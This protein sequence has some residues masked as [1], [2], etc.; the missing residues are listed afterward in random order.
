MHPVSPKRLLAAI[1]LA[2]LTACSGAAGSPTLPSGASPV[3]NTP[4]HNKPKAKT[5]F[6]IF[7]PRLGHNRKA[8]YVSVSTK[9]A[10]LNLAPAA[11]CNACTPALADD[12]ALTQGAPNCHSSGS[13]YVCDVVLALEP[14]IYSGSISLY[15]GP[16]AGGVATGTILSANQNFVFPIVSGAANT[17][18]VTLD[19]V[20][21]SVALHAVGS[22]VVDGTDRLYKSQ[23]V[24]LTKPSSSSTIEL[25]AIDPDGRVIIGPGAPTFT[26]SPNGGFAVATNGGNQ[27]TVTA[28]S[29]YL[30]GTYPLGI[31]INSNA[32]DEPGANC[33]S[34]DATSFN[35]GY[36]SFAAVI[37]YGANAIAVTAGGTIATVTNGISGPT[38]IAFDQH[39]NLFVANYDTNAIT[40]YAPPYTG[41]PITTI[42]TYVNVPG[43]MVVD[44]AGNLYL[45]SNT[46]QSID[47]YPASNYNTAKPADVS[48]GEFAD[49]IAVDSNFN[50]WVGANGVAQR[51]PT[52]VTTGSTPDQTCTATSGATSIAFDAQNDVFYTDG[53]TALAEC[54]RTAAGYGATKET[55]GLSNLSQVATFNLAHQAGKSDS[56]AV[57]AG[58]TGGS[59]I[60]TLLLPGIV[61]LEPISSL[62]DGFGAAFDQYGNAWVSQKSLSKVTYTP[63][64]DNITPGGTITIPN[65]TAIVVY[66]PG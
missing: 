49:T 22:A 9:S 15:D 42:T 64:Y 43:Q 29:T 23:L 53:S 51:F 3:G 38:S 24:L 12:F 36:Q 1:L 46:G 65:P 63:L 21:A 59:Y 41:A 6:E 40:E 58:G 32:C 10:A 26:F 55:T 20:P 33:G 54:D 39:A 31:T 4:A 56:L 44:S 14:G 60:A 8:R 18:A 27:Y 17:P 37:E 11:G 2:G 25:D 34:I 19:G 50:L 5:T 61:G 62:D 57:A 48:T 66:P 47:I 45:M 35:L 52:P 28:P 7:V 30:T 13:G 16:L